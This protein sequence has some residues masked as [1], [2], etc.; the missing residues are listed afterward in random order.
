MPETPPADQITR[1]LRRLTIAVWILAIVILLNLVVS[2]FAAL[3]P[4][5]IM[6]R[7]TALSPEF[8]TTEESSYAGFHDW[9]L[10]KQIAAATVIAIGRW[11]Q[12]DGQLKCIIA[13]VLKHQKDTAFYYK[14]GDEYQRGS[15]AVT[16]G[17]DYGD[18][19]IMFFTGSPATFRY[20][21]SFSRERASGMGDMPLEK[22]REMIKTSPQ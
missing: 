19:Q 6:K 21:T 10:E 11:K 2:L 17:T 8:Q 1:S 22:L 14:V 16:P 18:G 5:A 7:L 13:E 4:P 9:P 15:H 3:F 20:S 12:E